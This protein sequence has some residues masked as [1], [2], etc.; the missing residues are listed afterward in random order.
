MVRC[1]NR[2]P[3]FVTQTADRALFFV[4]QMGICALILLLVSGCSQF[5]SASSVSGLLPT[6]AGSS[7]SSDA[8]ENLSPVVAAESDGQ[9]TADERAF[10]AAFEEPSTPTA[11]LLAPDFGDAESSS[12]ELATPS[13]GGHSMRQDA[14]FASSN[15]YPATEPPVSQARGLFDEPEVETRIEQE[16]QLPGSVDRTVNVIAVSQP[17]VKQVGAENSSPEAPSLPGRIEPP[18]EPS[19][20]DRLRGFAPERNPAELLRRPFER[21][22]NPWDWDPFGDRNDENNSPGPNANT[23]EQSPQQS[24]AIPI[25]DPGN[26]DELLQTLIAISEQELEQWPQAEDE[27][28][29]QPVEF[30]RRQLN[31]RLLRLISDDPAAASEAIE[32]ISPEEQEFWQ[33]LILGISKFRDPK[34]EL[35]YDEHI[36]ATIGQLQQAVQQLEP[37]ASLAI[38]RLE[39]CSKIHSF[40]SIETFPSN[41]FGHGQQLLI[42]AEVDNLQ[43][44]LSPLGTYRTSFSG[45]LEIWS[46]SSAEP[47]KTWPLPPFVDESTTRRVD[48]YQHYRFSLPPHLPQ[49]DYEIRIQI[50]DD[51]SGRTVSDTL[52]FTIQ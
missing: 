22:P 31:L 38:R 41:T 27:S 51:I 45:T 32:T 23:M 18:Q 12:T 11:R 36:A 46:E 35:S 15:T 24:T 44:E 26:A 30:R 37:L 50:H 29:L 5:Q 42:Y 2:R 13:T 49:G 19:L 10:A 33:E 47:I 21:I 4:R 43:D 16:P 34:E 40:G 3:L 6:N 20:L 8:E 25:P 28:P 14:A 9:M 17:V 48:Y 52:D 1:A 7:V 39:F